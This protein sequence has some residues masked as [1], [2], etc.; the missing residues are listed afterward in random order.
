M[1]EAADNLDV[2]AV[3]KCLESKGVDVNKLVTIDNFTKPAI[4]HTLSSVEPDSPEETKQLQIVR[5]LADHKADPN[6]PGE[7]GNRALH[8]ARTPKVTKALLDLKADIDAANNDGNTALMQAT[9]WGH[10]DVVQVLLDHGTNTEIKDKNGKTALDH[11]AALAS[12]ADE[13]KQC[14]EL[15]RAHIAKKGAK[16]KSKPQQQQ[17]QQHPAA[18]ESKAPSKAKPTAKSTPAAAAT[19]TTSAPSKSAISSPVS[20]VGGLFSI[21]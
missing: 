14:Q 6:R 18:V 1:A 5:L 21:L 9:Y 15:I 20:K 8:F 13:H 17:P 2:E 10:A 7:R 12:L 16:A 4:L 11:K 3:K 19:T